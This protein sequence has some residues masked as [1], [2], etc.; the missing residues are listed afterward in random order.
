MPRFPI[1][2]VLLAAFSAACDRAQPTVRSYR[3]IAVAPERP[4]ATPP[5]SAPPAMGGMTGGD[6]ASTPVATAKTSLTWVLPSGWTEGPARA[7]RLAT[8]NVGTSGAECV[9]TV[10]PGDV[11]GLEANLRRWLGQLQVTVADPEVAKFS[12]APDTFQS[13]GGLPCLVYDFGTLVPAEKADSLLAA[14]VP[15]EGSTAFVKFAG[16]RALL[17]AEKDNFLAL[18]RSLKP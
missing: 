13:E 1:A 3:E 15:L 9:I 2:L 5:P 18:C 10:F 6:M 14:V 4:A 11:G 17:A 16:T 7:M 12:R 8:F